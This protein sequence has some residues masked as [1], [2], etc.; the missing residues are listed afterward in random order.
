MCVM[1]RSYGLMVADGLVPGASPPDLVPTTTLDRS[2]DERPGAGDRRLDLVRVPVRPSEPTVAV[3][4][5][6]A[7]R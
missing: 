5:V 7:D 3:V 4:G 1:K 2:R 6:R